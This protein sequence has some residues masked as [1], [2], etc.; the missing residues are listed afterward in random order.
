MGIGDA[1]DQTIQIE[2]GADRVW[3][4][5]Q[6]DGIGSQGYYYYYISDTRIY[7][8]GTSDISDQTMHTLLN[9]FS[10]V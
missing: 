10:I 5:I 1:K 8:I 7:V 9:G 6:S 2:V 4:C 3:R